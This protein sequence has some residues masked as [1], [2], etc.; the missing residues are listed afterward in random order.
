MQTCDN[1]SS[2]PAAFSIASILTPSTPGPPPFALPS[3]TP[4][5]T[6][7]ADRSGRTTRKTE[8]SAPLWP[9]RLAYVSTE[10]ISPNTLLVA[11]P[12]R[13]H[14]R[15]LQFF[16]SGTLCPSGSL[17]LLH[18]HFSVQAP[19]LHGRYPL[20][21][22]Y[23]PVLLPPGTG[24]RLFIPPNRL[25]YCGLPSSST[26]LSSRAVPFH[27]EAVRQLLLPVASLPVLGFIYF[28]RLATAI[29]PH[30]A[31]SVRVLNATAHTFASQGFAS[32]IT[33]SRACS[34]TCPIG[35]FTT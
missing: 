24:S 2:P 4:P 17:L 34:A 26:D 5:S 8:T 11:I 30:E 3:A 13:F 28:G 25:R 22:Y 35:Q 21:R 29:L 27:P 7:R 1:A 16:R 18:K 20:L 14:T 31:V 15:W 9:S 12:L 19:S 23:G 10:K 6:H 32:E 33:P